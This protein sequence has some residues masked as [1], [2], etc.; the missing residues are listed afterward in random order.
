M[1]ITHTCNLQ[2]V[3]LSQSLL[4][5]AL[6]IVCIHVHLRLQI[7]IETTFPLLLILVHA[8]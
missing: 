2:L 5:L 3:A 1:S 7:F 8:F 4:P 6:C